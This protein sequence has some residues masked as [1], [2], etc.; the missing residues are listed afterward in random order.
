MASPS[1][2]LLTTTLFPVPEFYIQH[3]SNMLLLASDAIETPTRYQDQAE[4]FYLG[5]S[6][7]LYLGSKLNSACFCVCALPF[8]IFL[9][10]QIQFRFKGAR[11]L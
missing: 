1:H 7:I 3:C 8:T 10:A 2:A 11:V 9:D 5:A 6:H 4:L